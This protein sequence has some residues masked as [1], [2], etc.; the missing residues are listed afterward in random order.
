LVGFEAGEWGGSLWWFSENGRRSKELRVSGD[1]GPTAA[2]G[3]VALSSGVFV[4]QGSGHEVGTHHPPHGRVVSVSPETLQVQLV[5]WLPHWP[6]AVVKESDTGVLVIAL[7]RIVRVTATGVADDLG[8]Y[9]PETRDTGS[10]GSMARDDDGT[11]W[12][13]MRHYV[14]HV[15]L[16]RDRVADVSWLAPDACHHFDASCGC[17]SF[18]Q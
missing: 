11:L 17:V 10:V 3:F 16:E 9:L 1:D 6:N 7:N 2:G 8:T 5:A 14:L 13:G 18:A 12:L 4:T 15:R